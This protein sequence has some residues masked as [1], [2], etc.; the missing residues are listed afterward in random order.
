MPLTFTFVLAA[1]QAFSLNFT[2]AGL[3]RTVDDHTHQP[4][5][6][7]RI[8]EQKGAFFGRIESSLD[9][10]DRREICDLCGDDRKNKPIIGLEILRGMIRRGEEYIGGFILDP[11]TGSVYRCKF[12]LSQ[13]GEK[14][15]MRGYLG[16]SLL[17]RSQVWTRISDDKIA[18]AAED[19]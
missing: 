6:T 17:G 15:F 8:Y 14:L 3:W 4:R 7:V 19:K 11:E 1:I 13:D 18:Q 5:G 2:P 9:P 10:K 12:T 16:I